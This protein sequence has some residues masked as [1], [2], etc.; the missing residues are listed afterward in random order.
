[1]KV[2]PD[3]SKT[4]QCVDMEGAE[5]V[6]MEMLVGEE[7]GA[8]NFVMR[9]FTIDAHG[10]TPFHTH[11]YEHVV[12]IVDGSGYLQSEDGPKSFKT[13]DAVFVAPGAKHQFVNDTGESL[14]FTC[15]IPK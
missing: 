8:P 7:D 14:K 11:E 1:M 5:G 2:I 3:G 15:T 6:Q 13:G 9:R 10:H 12:L 4:R